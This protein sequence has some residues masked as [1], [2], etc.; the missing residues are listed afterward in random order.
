MGFW[1]YISSEPGCVSA[2]RSGY[3]PEASARNRYFYEGAGKFLAYAS[4]LCVDQNLNTAKPNL[5]ILR[6]SRVADHEVVAWAA[7]IGI[8]GQRLR[9]RR[10]L[11][12]DIQQP[13]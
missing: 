6:F 2:R 8:D 10:G 4:G 3:E 13:R 7:S 11:L 12:R 1:E 9:R 5:N